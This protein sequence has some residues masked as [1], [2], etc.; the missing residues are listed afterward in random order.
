MCGFLGILHTWGQ[1]MQLHPHIHYIVACGS[2]LPDGE[3]RASD[4][5]LFDVKN[6]SK[7]FRG[8]YL[9]AL[10]RLFEAGKLRLPPGW[11]EA[12]LRSV[13]RA[14]TLKAWIVY[15]KETFCGPEKVIEYIG[16][17]AHKVAISEGRILEVGERD[18][19]FEWK[20]YRD[21]G[22]KKRR[23]VP[24]ETFVKTFAQHVL[25]VGFHR[26]RYYGFWSPAGLEKAREAIKLA[27]SVTKEAIHALLAVARDF[28][29]RHEEFGLRCPECSALVFEADA[30]K[31][32]SLMDLV[33][34]S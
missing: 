20:D 24:G 6:L 31:F 30:P 2:L 27:A 4:G 33:D 7:V 12:R 22:R 21:D 16:R 17:Y 8:K 5:Y 29:L 23:T 10:E 9:A 19:T 18:V 14:T 34:T 15:T 3:W 25:P 32:A 13:L 11:D 1:L 26:I 28:E